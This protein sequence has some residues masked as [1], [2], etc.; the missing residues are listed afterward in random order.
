MI[1]S[2]ESDDGLNAENLFVMEGSASLICHSNDA[3]RAEA[4]VNAAG[5]KIIP[6][7][8]VVT[9]ASCSVSLTREDLLWLLEHPGESIYA[10][11]PPFY[12]SVAYSQSTLDYLEDTRPQGTKGT[13]T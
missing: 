8:P 10:N 12:V 2:Y 4:A 13:N 7:V 9:Q 11:R 5:L 1:V 6:A 3:R